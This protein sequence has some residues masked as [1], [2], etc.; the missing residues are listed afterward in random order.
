MLPIIEGV[1]KIGKDREG[2]AVL[3]NNVWHSTVI[4]FGYDSS[5]ALLVNSGYQELKYVLW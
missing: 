5:R 2:E 4:D 1:Q 3:L